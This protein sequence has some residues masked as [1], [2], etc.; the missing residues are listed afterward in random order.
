MPKRLKVAIIDDHPVVRRGLAETFDE[1]PDFEVIAQGA[2][3]TDAIDIV[4]EK[5]PDIVLLDI[6]MP[7][8]GVEAA[9]EICKLRPE[10]AVIAFTMREE[11]A[12]VKA[13][14]QAGARGYILKGADSQYLIESVRRIHGGQS[15][16]SPELAAR[17]LAGLGQDTEGI[18]AV[19]RSPQLG[20]L[21]EREGQIFKLI[22]EGLTNLEIADRLGLRENTVKHYIT[23]LMQKLGVRNR[24]EAALLAR[25]NDI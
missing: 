8:G 15:F 9:R 14:L 24:T 19:A 25:R 2:T 16:V 5:R 4:R 7:G 22:G 21:T 13:F 11:L 18:P 12:T 1:A 23:P 10:I 20:A 6:S 17:L 3:A